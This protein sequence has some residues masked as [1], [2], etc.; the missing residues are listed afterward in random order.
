MENNKSTEELKNIKQK[1][2]K[3]CGYVL[4]IIDGIENHPDDYDYDMLKMHIYKM[5]EHYL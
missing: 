1:Y 5:K 2:H 4:G 3:M